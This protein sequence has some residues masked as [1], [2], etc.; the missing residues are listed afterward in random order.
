[1]NAFA[2]LLAIAVAGSQGT[3]VK[4]PLA[5]FNGKDL[6][7]WHVDCPE[8]DKNPSGPK[9][10]LVKDGVLVTPGAPPAHLIT[11]NA[12]ENYR[13]TVEYR[14]PDKAGN[15]GILIH[16]ST[17]RFFRDLLPK[18]LEVQLQ[19]GNA[20]DFIALGEDLEVPDMEKRRGPATN[21]RI[22]KLTQ[23]SEK[24]IGE[25]N[26]IVVEC[27]ADSVIV[28]VNG[29]LANF[30]YKGTARKGQIALQCEGALVEFRKVDLQPLG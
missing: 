16:C 27:R 9:P 3:E 11:D 8:L 5:L 1:M 24:P 17:P 28:W 18:S 25:W 6:D 26:T 21:R 30:G 29:D 13:L 12:F 23:N 22:P 19:S 20:G 15:N 7:G 14:Y 4:A 2:W 10:Y